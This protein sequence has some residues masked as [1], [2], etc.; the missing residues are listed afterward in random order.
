ML[1]VT[2]VTDLTVTKMQTLLTIF[3]YLKNLQGA[4]SL[5]YYHIESFVRNTCWLL[6][7]ALCF[8]K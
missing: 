8:L 4:V 1:F 7:L 5:T 2:Y 6:Q 3:Q